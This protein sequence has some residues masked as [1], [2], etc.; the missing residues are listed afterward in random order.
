MAVLSALH[1]YQMRAGARLTGEG[2]KRVVL[3]LCPEMASPQRGGSVQYLS[4]KKI[5]VALLNHE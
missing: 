1:T 5:L 4:L 2:G 3:T